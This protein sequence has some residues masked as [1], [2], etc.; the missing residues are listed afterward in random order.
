[1]NLNSYPL[2]V[3]QVKVLYLKNL[4]MKA[5]EEIINTTFKAYGD[6]DRVKKIKDYAFVHFKEREHAMKVY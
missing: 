2:C 3:V 4:S 1:M 6:V 5:T